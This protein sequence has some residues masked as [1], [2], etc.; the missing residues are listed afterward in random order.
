MTEATLARARAGDGDAFR[1]L[2]EPYRGELH[3]HCYRILG[4]LTDADDLLQETLLAAWRGLD[5][6]A[7]RASLR[8]WLYRIATNRCLNALRDGRRRV[9]AEPVPPFDPPEPT[10]RG[11]ATWLQPY[12]DALLEQIPDADPG[13]EVRYHGREAV[14][15]AFI[16]AL[17]QL[18]PRQTATLVLRDVLG[19]SAAEVADMLVTT[20]TAVKGTLQRARATLDRRRGDVTLARPGSA[21]ERDLTRRFADAFTADDINGVVALLTDDAWLAMPPAPHEYHGPDAIVSFL[22]ASTA[23]APRPPVQARRHPR[24]HPGRVRLVPPRPHP[25]DRP[26]GRADRAHPW[27]AP[28]PRHHPVPRQRPSAPVRTARHAHVVAVISG[29]ATTGSHVGLSTL[30]HA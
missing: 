21:E 9:P 12:P 24:Q 11:E 7:G 3:L 13:P 4:S 6:F 19:Y 5:T 14:E 1:E 26:P 23:L 18:P 27:P 10:R 28:D 15:L 20:E 25:T 17:Q 22:R 8:A 2:T 16:A 30:W 29:L